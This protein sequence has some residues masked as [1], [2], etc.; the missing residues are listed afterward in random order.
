MNYIFDITNIHLVSLFS[1]DRALHVFALGQGGDDEPRP[2][3][4]L[5]RPRA[6]NIC[7]DTMDSDNGHWSLNMTPLMA[8]RRV[9][10]HTLP[11]TGLMV[12]RLRSQDTVQARCSCLPLI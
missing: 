1:F 12:W 10:S 11:T 3:Q 6:P 2:K 9:A 7:L 8:R 4:H 5:P